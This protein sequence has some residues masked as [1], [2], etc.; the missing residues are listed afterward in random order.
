[1]IAVMFGGRAM[2]ERPAL[3]NALHNDAAGCARL[4]GLRATL[5]AFA[6]PVARR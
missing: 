1:M 5:Y 4:A 3:E 6:H 2:V